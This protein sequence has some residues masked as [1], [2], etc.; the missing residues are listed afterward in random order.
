MKK[1]NALLLCCGVGFLMS[2]QQPPTTDDVVN[3]MTE[4]SGGAEALAV[5]TDQVITWELTMNVGMPEGVEGPMIMQMTMTV[6]RSDKVRWDVYEPEGSIVYS[7]CYDG[8]TGWNMENSQRKDLTKAQLQEME[9]MATTFFDGFPI[10]QDKGV[11]LELL[12]DEVVDEQNYMVLQVTDKHDNVQKQ[13]INPE[14]HFIER[15]SG[16]IANLAGEWEHMIMTFKNYK[17]VDG[18]AWPHHMAHINATGEMT[19]EWTF[20]EVK[21]NTGVDDAVFMAE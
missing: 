15:E 12:A 17:M 10:H 8:T 5:L 20:K 4:A 9:S 13:Y 14:T 1:L 3:M 7:R 18:I 11:T 6:K 2:C 16:N 21:Y 19:M